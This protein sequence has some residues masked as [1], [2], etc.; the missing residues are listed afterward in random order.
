LAW[1]WAMELELVGDQIAERAE[2]IVGGRTWPCAVVVAT[3]W[4]MLIRKG[5][6]FEYKWRPQLA[7]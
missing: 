1:G 3:S 7:G 6:G 5:S 2:M 4:K